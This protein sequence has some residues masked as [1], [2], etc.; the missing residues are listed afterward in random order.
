VR[1]IRIEVNLDVRDDVD[2]D[3]LVR[4][5]AWGACVYGVEQVQAVRLTSPQYASCPKCGAKNNRC[6]YYNRPIGCGA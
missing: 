2:L 6:G 4:R 1:E 5:V 3:D